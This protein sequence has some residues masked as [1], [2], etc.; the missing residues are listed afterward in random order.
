MSYNGRNL[1]TPTQTWTVRIATG[2]AFTFVAAMPTTRAELVLFNGEPLTGNGKSYIIDA[3]W[4][5]GITSAAA[6][7]QM[8]LI[9]QIVTGATAPTDD[10]AQLITS[11]SCMGT[12]GGLAKR[13]VAQTTMV[14]NKWELLEF[15]NSVGATTT[16]GLGMY[17]NVGGRLIVKPGAMLGVNVVCGAAAGTGIMGIAWS[18]TLLDF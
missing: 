17:S 3:I 10:T 13:A 5:L 2:S 15:S 9:A 8:A 11:N 18:E 12:Y 6:A 16:I 1:E 7:Q 4:C 14:A